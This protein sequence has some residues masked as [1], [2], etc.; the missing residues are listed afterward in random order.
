[1]ATYEQDRKTRKQIMAAHQAGHLVVAVA[2]GGSARS[3]I[4]ESDLED[5]RQRGIWLGDTTLVAGCWNRAVGAAGAIAVHLT[6]QP[7]ASFEECIFHLSLSKYLPDSDGDLSLGD[8]RELLDDVEGAFDLLT[9]NQQFFEWAVAELMSE[10]TVTEGMVHQF[11][12][13]GAPAPV[14]AVAADSKA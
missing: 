8:A 13:L 2:M 14:N 6:H 5:A 3:W 7:D 12:H 10:G 4:W 1:M 9:A 11:Y